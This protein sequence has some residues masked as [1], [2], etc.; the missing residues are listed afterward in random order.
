MY[1]VKNLQYYIILVFIVSD[2]QNQP[3]HP[4]LKK[5]EKNL[6]N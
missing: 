5:Q 4:Q 3:T 1:N 6:Q 2:L